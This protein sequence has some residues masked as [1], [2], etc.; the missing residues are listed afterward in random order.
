MTSKSSGIFGE[1][2]A[3][4]SSGGSSTGAVSYAATGTACEI[5]ASGDNAGK[6]VITSGTGTCAVTA[7]QAGD[8]NYNPVSSAAQNVS[9]SKAPQSAALVVT[10]TA[11]G[12]Y[13]DTLITLGSTGGSGTGAVTY[14][15]TGTACRMD[16]GKLLI[17]SG[18]GTCSVTATKAADAN[19]T[20]AMSPAKT[21]TPTAW[22]VGGFYSPVDMGGIYNTVKGGSTVPVKFELFAGSRE[23]TAVADAGALTAKVVSCNSTATT[24]DIEVMATGATELRYDTTGGQ[25]IYNWKTPTGAGKCYQLTLTARDGSTQTALFKMK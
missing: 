17:T 18:T 4:T 5:P 7:T 22:K 20:A 2:I 15:A 1:V 23:L 21:I 24:D 8:N 3:L 10:T 6:L 16:A 14:T 11:D 19:Y 13:I 12:G 25:Y 9:V